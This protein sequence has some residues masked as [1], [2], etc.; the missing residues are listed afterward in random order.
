[1]PKSL[2][3]VP[4]NRRVLLLDLVWTFAV[5]PSLGS[6]RDY[7]RV[8]EASETYRLDLLSRIREEGFHVVLLTARSIRYQIVTLANIAR[9][10]DGWQP[11][12]AFFNPAKQLPEV[13]KRE[14]LHQ[15]ILPRFGEDRSCYFALE[16]NAKTRA[17]YQA[18]KITATTWE[19]YL[20]PSAPASAE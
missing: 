11:D 9:H 12:T 16:S 8:I 15:S 2:V 20:G 18:E 5:R 14:A 19:S 3:A 10:A 7:A 4:F 1:M 13:W 17:M 6:H